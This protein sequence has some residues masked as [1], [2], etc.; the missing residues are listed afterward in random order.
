MLA[1]ILL[2]VARIQFSARE[3]LA[4]GLGLKEIVPEVGNVSTARLEAMTNYKCCQLLF[5]G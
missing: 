4:M 3:E 2:L 1:E 5:L